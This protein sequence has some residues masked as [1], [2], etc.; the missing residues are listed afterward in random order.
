MHMMDGQK[1][2]SN[3]RWMTLRGKH[4]RQ[5]KQINMTLTSFCDTSLMASSGATILR[6]F[7]LF[8]LSFPC[9]H[10][11]LITRQKYTPRRPS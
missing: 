4:E 2:K 10:Q 5:T 6:K 1:K 7:L 9:S 8:S 11:L 3:R